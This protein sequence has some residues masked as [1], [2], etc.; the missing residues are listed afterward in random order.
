M[1]FGFRTR[2][3][4]YHINPLQLTVGFSL[5]GLQCPFLSSHPSLI[6]G[7]GWRISM[8]KR[9]LRFFCWLAA[10]SDD[11]RWDSLFFS[12]AFQTGSGAL[13]KWREQ[14]ANFDLSFRKSFWGD[15]QLSRKQRESGPPHAD[16]VETRWCVARICPRGHPNTNRATNLFANKRPPSRRRW[17]FTRWLLERPLHTDPRTTR[18]S[19]NQSTRRFPRP[20][21]RWPSNEADEGFE[22]KKVSVLR[23]PKTIREAFTPW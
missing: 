6:P 3:F 20:R 14:S 10:F 17:K 23:V 13:A 11:A 22:F 2:S 12:Q 19:T 15:V 4:F 8:I 18:L 9:K 21:V 1:R 5:K 16:R 7:R